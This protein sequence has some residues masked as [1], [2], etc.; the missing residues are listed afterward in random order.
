MQNEAA[1][2]GQGRSGGGMVIGV[3]ANVPNH[4]PHEPKSQRQRDYWRDLR[5]ATWRAALINEITKVAR[6]IAIEKE[7]AD[8]VT[9]DV[10]AALATITQARDGRRRVIAD[11]DRFYFRR[12]ADDAAHEAGRLL[13]LPTH[14]APTLTAL[15]DALDQHKAISAARV[16]A[17]EAEIAVRLAFLAEDN[18]WERRWSELRDV[19]RRLAALEREAAACRN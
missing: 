18:T 6:L 19:E 15:R 10:T 1:A 7:I 13:R 12:L 17:Y 3:S 9:A 4:T 2:P 11:A 8:E 14:V 5:L 16:E